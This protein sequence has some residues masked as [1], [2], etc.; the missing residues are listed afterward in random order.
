[1]NTTMIITMCGITIIVA[2]LILWN[3]IVT[4]DMIRCKQCPY[5]NSLNCWECRRKY[6]INVNK[7]NK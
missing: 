6:S 5:S 4:K 7:Y 1:M 3:Y 2:A